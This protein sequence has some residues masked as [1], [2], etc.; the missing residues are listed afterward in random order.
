MLTRPPSR[1]AIDVD[2]VTSSPGTPPAL[3]AYYSQIRFGR[4]DILAADVDVALPCGAGGRACAPRRPAP[5]A[6]GCGGARPHGGAALRQAIGRCLDC[7]TAADERAA[8][9]FEPDRSRR[10]PRA[11]EVAAGRLEG[12]GVA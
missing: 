1:V 5:A 2:T 4:G 12:S 6:T 7:G 9:R 8:P 11:D 3:E 10:P